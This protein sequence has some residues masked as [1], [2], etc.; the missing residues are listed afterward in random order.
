MTLTNEMER[1][2]LRVGLGGVGVQRRERPYRVVLGGEAVTSG[3]QADGKRVGFTVAAC[4]GAGRT[5]PVRLTSADLVVGAGG[6]TVRFR[7]PV[8]CPRLSLA[9]HGSCWRVGFAYARFAGRVVRLWGADIRSRS[10]SL[11]VTYTEDDADGIVN[12]TLAMTRAATGRRLWRLPWTGW[13]CHFTPC[14][15][16]VWLRFVGER[17][18]GPAELQ[19]RRCADGAVMFRVPLFYVKKVTPDYVVVQEEDDGVSLLRFGNSD[20]APRPTFPH[21]EYQ[22]VNVSPFG[23]EV[24]VRHRGVLVAFRRREGFVVPHPVRGLP[25]GCPMDMHGFAVTLSGEFVWKGRAGILVAWDPKRPTSRPVCFPSLTRHV[26]PQCTRWGF[27]H[28]I[29]GAEAK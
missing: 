28:L 15:R 10:G 5:V 27:V 7:R 19:L 9:L 23:D 6:I 1:P 12:R 24:Y 17:W 11:L 20:G 29:D 14:G 13:F 25:E 26:H 22:S 18:E 3:L 8:P 16:Y 4:D 21:R 2:V